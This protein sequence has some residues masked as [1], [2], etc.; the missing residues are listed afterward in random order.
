MPQQRTVSSTQ[1]DF[2]TIVIKTDGATEFYRQADY[3]VVYEFSGRNFKAS[4]PEGIYDG[5]YPS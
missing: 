4:K 5:S 3:P 1:I 2:R